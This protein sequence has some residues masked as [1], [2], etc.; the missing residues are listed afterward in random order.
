MKLDN[1]FDKR[2]KIIKKFKTIK[3]FKHTDQI[4]FLLLNKI[5]QEIFKQLEYKNIDFIF[6]NIDTKY[7]NKLNNFNDIIISDI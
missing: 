3:D 5:A 7:K 4:Q 2:F 6:N 1:K